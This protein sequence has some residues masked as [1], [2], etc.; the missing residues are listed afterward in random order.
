MTPPS[1][2][3]NLNNALQNPVGGITTQAPQQEVAPEQNQQGARVFL[4][5]AAVICAAFVCL[6]SRIIGSANKGKEKRS[7]SSR[8][9]QNDDKIDNPHLKEKFV[10]QVV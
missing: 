5:L 3:Y 1:S 10:T 9:R 2:Y 7:K 4:G 8:R 6:L